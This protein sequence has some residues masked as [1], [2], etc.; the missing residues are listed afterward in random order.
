MLSELSLQ[1][2]KAVLLEFHIPEALFYDETGRNIYSRKNNSW[3][4]EHLPKKMSK[5]RGNFYLPIYYEKKLVLYIE[6]ANLES[7]ITD[8]AVIQNLKNVIELSLKY[9]EKNPK[10]FNPNLENEF[11]IDL[12]VRDHL[13]AMEQLTE[14]AEIVNFNLDKERILIFIDIRNF[15]K[16]TREEK[17]SEEI[18]ENL[19]N[20]YQL[21]QQSLETYNEYAIYLYDDKFIL[22]K[23]NKPQL[24]ENLEKLRQQ[25]IN[26]LD[27]NVLFIIGQTCQSIEDY[28]LTFKKIHAFHQTQ[29]RK[30]TTQ[31]LFKIEDF[32]IELLLLGISEEAQE[33]FLRSKIQELENLK[34]KHLEFIETFRVFYKHNLN[35]KKTAEAMYLHQNTIYYRIKRMSEL[36]DLNLFQT[37]DATHVFLALNLLKN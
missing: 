12:I 36:L 15:K 30:D 10:K 37:V 3:L 19:V 16:I 8:Q 9:I 28:H 5:N 1:Y 4:V 23:E 7:K 14:Q 33:L 17:D 24:K 2:I 29:I 20:V 13:G 32:E 6:I 34:S 18:Q 22:L 26:Q 21:L 35:T 11:L 27:L 25:I 31:N